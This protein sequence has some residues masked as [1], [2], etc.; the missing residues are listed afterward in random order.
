[1]HTCL[2]LSHAL[3]LLHC[4]TAVLKCQS[5]YAFLRL[6]TFKRCLQFTVEDLKEDQ[7]FLSGLC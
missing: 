6:K 2:P 5:L 7:L 4:V 1:M 3:G